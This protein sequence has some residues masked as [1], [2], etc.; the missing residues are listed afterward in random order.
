M[1]TDLPGIT[2]LLRLSSTDSTQAVARFLAEQGAPDRT[3]V[4]ADR[5]TAGRGRMKRRWTSRAGGL[6]F[7]LI[8]RPSFP[9]SRLAD[10]SLATAGAAAEALAVAGISCA[11]KPPN[12][13]IGSRG[14]RSGKVCGILA[15]ASGGSRSVDWVALGVGINVNNSVSGVK[16]AASL[17]GLTGRAWEPAEVLRS[18]LKSFADAYRDF[19]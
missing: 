16:G 8:L 12:D 15:E 18:F 17:K 4:W 5:Q 6:Y 19:R 11:V 7:S 1:P 10:F 14:K 3:V 9:P 13:V 2:Q